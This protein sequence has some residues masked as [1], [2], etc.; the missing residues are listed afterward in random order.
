MTDV[1]VRASSI[2]GLGVFAARDFAE[3]EAVLIL[4]DSR[5]V[6][7][8]HPLRPERGEYDYHCDY[9]AGGRVVLQPF[10][11]RH[12]NSSCD[13]NTYMKTVEG[14]GHGNCSRVLRS[15][16]VEN[17]RA[18]QINERLKD[19]TA[20]LFGGLNHCL[21]RR[22]GVRTPFGAEPIGHLAMNH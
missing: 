4:D 6:D 20:L 10:P 8:G 3:G 12:I 13:P 7:D 14:V 1:I 9:L 18:H 17:R 22:I 19:T 5:V 21:K 2:H 11:E 16:E 15:Q